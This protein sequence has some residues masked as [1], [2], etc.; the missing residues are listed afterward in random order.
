MNAKAN[1]T[2]DK[3]RELQRKLYLSVKA[4]KKRKFHALYDKIYRADILLKA[5]KQ[6]KSNK[7]TGGIDEVYIED[8]VKC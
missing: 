5:W 7:G 1:N 4:N 8:V 2:I 3:V 6:V